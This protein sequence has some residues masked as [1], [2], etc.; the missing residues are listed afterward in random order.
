MIAIAN[1]DFIW[2]NLDKTGV[3]SFTIILIIAQK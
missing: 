3:N 2:L 1:G